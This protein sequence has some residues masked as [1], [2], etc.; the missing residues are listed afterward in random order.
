MTAV[1]LLTPMFT[2][3]V[4]FLARERII[5]RR[6][7]FKGE[8]LDVNASRETIKLALLAVRLMNPE[9]TLSVEEQA[10]L[11]GRTRKTISARRQGR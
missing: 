10:L 5:R 3:E 9:E 11:Q 6:N 7:F 4:L 1:D 2:D 8:S